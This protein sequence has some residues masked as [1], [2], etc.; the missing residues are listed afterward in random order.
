MLNM[1]EKKSN[2]TCDTPA[3]ILKSCVN[4]YISLL[5]KILNTSLER[6]CFSNQIKLAEVT[7]V[8]KTEDEL[9]SFSCVQERRW[10]K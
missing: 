3:E 10:A 1:D 5:T 7:P 9:G 6:S 4:S 2:L 8:L